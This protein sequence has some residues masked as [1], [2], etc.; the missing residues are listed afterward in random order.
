M[1]LLRYLFGTALFWLS[2]KLLVGF[3][4]FLRRLWRF[5]PF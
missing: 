4:F 2:R 3:G 1:F 5:L